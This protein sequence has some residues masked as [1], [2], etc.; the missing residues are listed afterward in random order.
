MD[1]AVLLQ[2]LDRLTDNDTAV[3][4]VADRVLSIFAKRR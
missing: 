3:R 2:V 1:E 4:D